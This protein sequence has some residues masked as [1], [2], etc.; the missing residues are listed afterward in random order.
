M[1]GDT[2]RPTDTELRILNVL[3]DRGPST[4]R[5]V[6]AGLVAHKRVGYTTALKMLQVMADKGLVLRDDTGW[7]HRFAP[8]SDRASTQRRL[9]T[10]LVDRAFGG[11]ANAL[12]VQALAGAAVTDEERDEI[13]R[14]LDRAEEG[15]P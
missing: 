8:R 4:V 13:R 5:E 15:N 14:M 6:H 1:A 7:P 9:L 3:W 10:D 12:V 2:P 11:S